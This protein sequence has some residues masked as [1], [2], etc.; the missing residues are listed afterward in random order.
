MKNQVSMLNYCISS[1]FKSVFIILILVNYAVLLG[2]SQPNTIP[3]LS[4]WLTPENGIITDLSGQVRQWNDNSALMNNA[5]QSDSLKRPLLKTNNLLINHYSS[6]TFDGTNDFMAFNEIQD[7][8]TVFVIFKHRTGDAGGNGYQPILGHPILYDFIG[9]TSTGLFYTTYLNSNIVNGNIYKNG[10]LTDM[11]LPKPSQYSLLSIVTSGNVAANYITNDR[12]LYGYWDGDFV[13]IIIY[14][15][16]LNDADRITVENYLMNKYAPSLNFAQ[17]TINN[18]GFCPVTLT[19]DSIYAVYNWSNGNNTNQTSVSQTGYYKLTVTDIFGRI[20]SDS[21]YV[22]YPGSFT[23]PEKLCENDTLNI[24]T[25]LNPAD[26]DFLWQNG[27]TNSYFNITQGGTYNVTISDTL[28]CIFVS[29]NYVVTLDTFPSTELLPDSLLLCFGDTI[30]INCTGAVSYEW[31]DNSTNSYNIATTAGFVFVTVSNSYGCEAIDS[32]NLFINGTRPQPSVNHNE[33]CHQKPG[34]Y[35]GSSTGNIESWQWTF[36]DNTTNNSQNNIHVYSQPGIYQTILEVI[37][38]NGCNGFISLTDTVYSSPVSDFNFTGGCTNHESIFMSVPSSVDSLSAYTWEISGNTLT[39]D[40]IG[41][42]FSQNGSFTVLHSVETING[43]KD[44]IS[45]IISISDTLPLP[46]IANP[47]FPQ[48][49]VNKNDS[50]IS[51]IWNANNNNVYYKIEI[52]HDPSFNQIYKSSPL[53]TL[54]HFSFSFV[55]QDTTVYWRV[56]SYNGC[57]DSTA[58]SYFQLF[59]Y[60]PASYQGLSVWYD[61]SDSTVSNSNAVSSWIDK[62]LNNNN[63]N[64]ADSSKRPVLVQNITS[65]NHLSALR[66][67]GIDDFMEFNKITDIRTVFILCKHSTGTSSNYPPLLGNPVDA[68]FIGNSGSNLFAPVYMPPSIKNGNF[69]VNGIQSNVDSILKPVQYEIV[70]ISTTDSATAQYITNDRN[71][72]GWWEGDFPEI[73]IYNRPLTIY[74][75]QFV[76]KYLMDKY[77]PPVNI[78]PDIYSDSFCDTALVAGDWF[79]SYHWSTGETQPSVSVNQSGVYWVSVTDIFG[80]VSID[81]INVNFPEAL[82]QDTL[83]V[84]LYDSILI[85]SGLGAKYQFLWSNGSTGSQTYFSQEGSGWVTVTDERGCNNTFW[86]YVNIDSLQSQNIF[87]NDTIQICYGNSISADVGNHNIVTYFWQPGSQSTPQVQPLLSGWYKVTVTDI[88][89]CHA[90][91]SVYSNIQGIAPVPGFSYTNTC[92]GDQTIFTDTSHTLDGSTISAW[93]W[94]VDNDTLSTQNISVSF[95]TTNTYDVQLT[96]TTTS[97]CSNSISESVIIFPSPHSLFSVEGTCEGNTT[98]FTNLSY[99]PLGYLS[100]WYWDFGD[101]SSSSLYHT[102]HMYSGVGNYPVTLRVVNNFGCEDSLISNVQIKL[103]PLAGFDFSPAC[104]GNLTWFFDTSVVSPVFPIIDRYWDF[105]DGGTDNHQNPSY[106]YAAIGQY[107]VTMTINSLNGCTSTATNTVN[108]SA[109]PE[110]GF[111]ADS[112]CIGVPLNF[113]DTSY[114]ENGSIY[115]WKWNFGN[116]SV[117]NLQ[118]PSAYFNVEGNYLVKL[119]VTSDVDCKDSTSKVVHVYSL[120]EIDFSVNPTIGPPGMQILTSNTSSTGYNYWTFGDGQ[121]SQL[122]TPVHVYTDTGNFTIWLK[123][124]NEHGCSDSSSVAVKIVP[125]IYNLAILNLSST[126]SNGYLSAVTL[127]ANVGT[128]PIINPSLILYTDIHTPVM[129]VCHDTIYS[130]QIVT[131]NFNS[132]LPVTLQNTPEYICAKGML[133]A[134]QADADLTNNEACEVLGESNFVLNLYPNPASSEINVDLYIALSGKSTI[135]I[136]DKAG[137]L[138]NHQ[139]Y[140]LQTGFNRLII[141]VRDYAKGKYNIHL[142]V[143]EGLESLE[144]VKY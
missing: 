139:E 137:R 4:L 144:F 127:V 73:I 20:S 26:Y 98:Y 132:L 40:S 78:G 106:T 136:V 120:P 16:P 17:D 23:V 90:A 22:Q 32:T 27:D 64:Q 116:G 33:L 131:Y 6:L 8:R 9:T 47:V 2:F 29:D 18:Y 62:S 114:A 71:Q 75:K 87:L 63:A 66:F 58:S 15:Q 121:T 53:I 126:R 51:F 107:D 50:I 13:E 7:I 76:E 45:K 35:E 5:L 12:N 14:N 67:D 95:A 88:N 82:I 52:A 105:G 85:S 135:E 93:Q 101:N 60:S 128:M 123:I 61:A 42:Q 81:S 142:V 143:P 125:E 118:N 39:G 124:Q 140:E 138:V 74:E 34:L 65:L 48:N 36:G 37:D 113:N 72:Y 21:V 49:G 130:G 115:K 80:R 109:K 112:A 134:G 99:T 59:R 56:L 102:Q 104:T 108:V 44:T 91:D 133:A 96:V 77:A 92:Q 41:F 100:D 103:S 46:V 3:G 69:Y 119:E 1:V 68:M 30:N 28:G 10:I 19:A 110:A 24:Q 25:G 11:Y 86:F 84:C 111:I 122:V 83:S 89:N 97:N 54:N 43:C 38:S 79:T 141:D 70:T 55:Q 129:E 94:I 31:S 57:L 117:S